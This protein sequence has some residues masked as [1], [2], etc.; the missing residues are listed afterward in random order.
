[1]SRQSQP[2]PQWNNLMLDRC[3]SRSTNTTAEPLHEYRPIYIC[4]IRNRPNGSNIPLR[5]THTYPHVHIYTS[6][7][8]EHAFIKRSSMVIA[9]AVHA[10]SFAQHHPVK[11]KLI[12]SDLALKPFPSLLERVTQSKV[13]RDFFK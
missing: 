3:P 7:L 11:L 10:T 1:M 12:I 2:P 13:T 5:Y 9:A 6:L 4:H 8:Y